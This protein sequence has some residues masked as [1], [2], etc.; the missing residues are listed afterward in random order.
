MKFGI[1]ALNTLQAIMIIVK[2]M[3]ETTCKF[4]IDNTR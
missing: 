1:T 2:Q 3:K 4:Y